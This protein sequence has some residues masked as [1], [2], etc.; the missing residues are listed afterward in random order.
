MKRDQYQNFLLKKSEDRIQYFYPG[1]MKQKIYVRINQVGKYKDKIGY[2]VY[3]DNL[4]Q[5]FYIINML[6]KI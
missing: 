2:I 6:D 1:S 3:K 4:N 5:C